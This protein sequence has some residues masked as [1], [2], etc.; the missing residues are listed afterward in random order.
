MNSKRRG[1]VLTMI[2]G[3]PDSAEVQ[4][5]EKK[6]WRMQRGIL[7]AACLLVIGLYAYTAQSGLLASNSLDPADAYYN[8][9]VRGFRAGQLNLK[10]DVPGFAQL[11]NPYDPAAHAPY[12]VLD[13]S[14][15]KGKFYL[16]FGV[17]PALV[18]FWPFALLTG[19]YLSQ[20][21]AVICFC[22][23]GLLA[24]VGLLCALWRRYFAE[25]NVA[26]VAAGA[27]ALGLATCVP[28]LL[29]RCD[30]YEVAI[31]CGY[32]FTML[33]LA[34]IWKAIHD[35]SQKGAWL[36]GAS[37][38]YG[39]A[40]GARPSL[41][42]GAV[43]LLV[44]VV[45]TWRERRK[46]WGP[47]LAALGPIT[48]IGIGLMFYNSLRFDNPF[49]FGF[50]YQLA[51]DRELT[52]QPFSLRYLWFNFRAY[53]LELA[54]WS[55]RFPFVRNTIVAPSPAGHGP[56]EQTFGILANIP[57]VW[58]ALAVPLAWRGRSP[59]SRHSLDWFL[60]S[61]ALLFGGA[62]LT[63]GCYY[64]TAGRYEVEFLPALVLLAVT[65]I[66]ATERA[67]AGQPVRRRVMRW[68]WS[69]LLCFS[70]AFNLLACT[71]R[72]AESHDNQGM[73]LQEIGRTEE[74]FSQYEE[75]LRLNPDFAQAHYNLGLALERLGRA[76]E[77]IEH[78]DQAIRI[79]SD[80][81][82]AHNNLAGILRNQ[83]KLPEA[84]NHYEQAARGKPNL[85]GVQFNLGSTLEQAGRAE[86]AIGQ[87]EQAIRI[88]PD[89]AYAHNN[90][91]VLLMARG[92]LQE[93]VDHF[94][95]ALR[96]QPDNAE[97]HF[98]LAL[99]S[100]RLG[101]WQDAIDHYQQVV[102]IKPDLVQARR[103][104]AKAL[105][106][107]GKVPEAIEQFDLALRVQPDDADTHNNL[108]LAL[109]WSGRIREATAQYERAL[110]I[111]PDFAPAQTNLAR[112]RAI[113]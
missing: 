55:N 32:A 9:L 48:L 19:N 7:C 40:V 104:L 66:L 44:P 75:A 33:A 84:I 85:A 47:L 13:M 11:A 34:C 92:R 16:Y 29:A 82:D 79:Q 5:A 3:T 62:A 97:A 102:R 109:E 107:T 21:T 30:V 28:F 71:E 49:E 41:L 51:G 4:G 76:Q 59:E 22:I 80:Y 111:K 50:R 99:A 105:L 108:G 89:F 56:V 106:Q 63:L 90:L 88:K 110:Q 53:F 100:S 18:L 27:L 35:S 42:F 101:R 8:L 15:Y 12:P 86:E 43:V 1:L 14:Y 60:T 78:Y 46:V 64:Y 74:A 58:L 10:I 38:M 72:W 94:Q 24:G 70:V 17:T 98:N 77:A 95:Q 96:I 113:Q 65:G 91:G 87:Y 73:T 37:L 52:Q 54:R 67:L 36:V 69:V 31:S 93:A 81:A 103:N 83:G 39:L 68:A 61:V 25:V 45:Q 2:D 20:K 57:L 112:V 23:V 26:V 6:R